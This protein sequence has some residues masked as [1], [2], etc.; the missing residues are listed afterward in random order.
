MGKDFCGI[1]ARQAAVAFHCFVDAV[2]FLFMLA[3]GC[4]RYTLEKISIHV[5]W[6]GCYFIVVIA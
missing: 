4:Q 6:V 2:Q 1:P 5:L 3:H